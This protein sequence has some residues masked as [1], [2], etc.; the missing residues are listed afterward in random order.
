MM[1]IKYSVYKSAYLRG[2]K[3]TTFTCRRCRRQIP[4]KID[5]Q[6]EL[7]TPSVYKKLEAQ[8]NN[9]EIPTVCIFCERIMNHD[10]QR[11]CT[12]Y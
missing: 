9:Y 6:L 1:A 11:R 12:H 3:S 7:G 5:I 2:V 4:F 8:I 10:A